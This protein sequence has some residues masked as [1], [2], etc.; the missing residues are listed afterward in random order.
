[1]LIY[2]TIAIVFN[3]I[4]VSIQQVILSCFYVDG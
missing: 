2:S 1:L 3:V 4:A